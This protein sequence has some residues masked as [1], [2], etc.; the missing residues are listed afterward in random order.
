MNGTYA[1][2]TQVSSAKS[3]QEIESTIERYGA[4]EFAFATKNGVAMIGFVLYDRQIRFVLPLPAR[5]DKAFR[6]TPTG[7]VRSQKARADAYEQ[8]VRQKWRALALVI[9]AK[10]EAVE[11][12]ITTFDEEFLANIVLPGGMTVYEA[13]RQGFENALASGTPT[14]FLSIE[15]RA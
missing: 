1:N 2:S 14:S 15:G 9:K 3:R 5:D 10:L 8:A 13:T 12:G 7:L 6:L 4:D 11:S